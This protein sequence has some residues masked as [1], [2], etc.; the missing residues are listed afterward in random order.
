MPKGNTNATAKSTSGSPVLKQRSA[1]NEISPSKRN[2]DDF[3]KRFQRKTRV[4]K[5]KAKKRIYRRTIRLRPCARRAIFLVPVGILLIE[6]YLGI[7]LKLDHFT[8]FYYEQSG[9]EPWSI[10][11]VLSDRLGTP[12]DLRNLTSLSEMKCSHDLRKMSSLNKPRSYY[13]QSR[14]IPAIVH[15]TAESPCLTLNFHRAAKKWA[16]FRHWSYYFHDDDAMDRLL[17]SSFPEFPHLKLVVEN[18]VVL[19]SVKLDL[20]RFLVLWVYGG[21][22][23]D[24]NSYPENFNSATIEA[25]DDGFF[26]L[27]PE[28]NML[29]TSLMAVSPR[30]P[31]MYYAIQHSLGNILRVEDVGSIDSSVTTGPGALEQA[32]ISFKG[33]DHQKK[34]DSGDSPAIIQGDIKGCLGRSIRVAGTENDYFV[35]IF[36]S[37]QGKR[38]EFLK[39]GIETMIQPRDLGNCFHE[40]NVNLGDKVH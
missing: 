34:T 7:L 40:I 5:P 18:C 6:R 33:L 25:N 38:K 3:F 35:Q 9:L 32:F 15:Q 22:I 17:Q 10:D 19:P 28:T 39:M 31:L 2:R 11:H 14:K 21:V 4:Q 37:D 12:P 23:P 1:R 16:A 29:S 36:I 30:H 26:L 8:D 27:D 20:W 13:M 24:I